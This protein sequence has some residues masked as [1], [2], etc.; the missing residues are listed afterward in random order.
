MLLKYK[1][2]DDT[3]DKSDKSDDTSDD[4]SNDILDRWIQFFDPLFIPNKDYIQVSQTYYDNPKLPNFNELKKESYDKIVD[5]IKSSYTKL[6]NIYAERAYKK[7]SE[8]STSRILQFLYVTIVKYAM[9][10][11]K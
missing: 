9:N 11:N 2:S 1:Q 4:K 8:L 10:M 6:E 5:D 7:I 3:Y